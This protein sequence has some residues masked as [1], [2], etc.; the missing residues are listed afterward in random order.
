MFSFLVKFSCLTQ[1]VFEQ[2][3]DLILQHSPHEV[4]EENVGRWTWET[5]WQVSPLA[6]PGA[7]TPP[8]AWPRDHPSIQVEGPAAPWAGPGP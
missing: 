5:D 4:S 6:L 3:A 2:P 1:H 8:P 7:L